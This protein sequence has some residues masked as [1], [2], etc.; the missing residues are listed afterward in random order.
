LRLGTIGVVVLLWFCVPATAGMIVEDFDTG[1]PTARWDVYDDPTYTVMAP[2]TAGR[3]QISKTAPYQAYYGGLFSK[4]TVDGDVCVTV[5]FD[6]LEFP[7]SPYVMNSSILQLSLG[8]VNSG[9]ALGVNRWT[10]SNQQLINA[11]SKL[12]GHLSW[13][14]N[15]A[16]SGTMKITRVG[17]TMSG[18]VDTGAGFVFVG[19]HSAT[20]FLGPLRVSIYLSQGQYVQM[21]LDVR[22]D[23]LAVEADV[24][25]E[26][27][28]L[29]LLAVVGCAT[30]GLRR[31]R[32]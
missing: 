6:L 15:S 11:Y 7:T 24:I 10:D 22:I 28:T 2:D 13:I 16:M 14:P 21:P 23:N 18:H 30:A 29:A 9:Y 19:S 17:Q 26:P 25:P 3:M 27:S 8:A 32:S 12:T 4:F 20:E 1:L 5:S 31:R